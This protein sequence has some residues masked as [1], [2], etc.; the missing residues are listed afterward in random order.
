MADE[1][2]VAAGDVTEQVNAEVS[3]DAGESGAADPQ[4]NAN[5]GEQAEHKRLGGWQRKIQKLEREVQTLR[6]KAA[7]VVEQ[8]A[9]APK[10]K[11]EPKDFQIEGTETYD[12]AKYAEAVADWK[13]ESRLAEADKKRTEAQKVE[14][15]KSEQQKQLEAWDSK[16]GAAA[17]AK[18]KDFSE[19]IQSAD[20]PVSPLMHEAIMASDNGGDLA[21]YFASNEEQ[22]LAISRMSPY[23]QAKEIAKI[24]AQFA[25]QGSAEEDEH[26]DAP[27]PPVKK[28]PAPPTPVSKPSS[29]AHQFDPVK[30]ADMPYKDWIRK[31]EAQLKRK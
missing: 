30:D 9:E 27:V 14:Q 1:Q 29:A 8:V 28:A 23:Q 24:E 3:T 18:Y 10:P 15:Q 7:P 11:P 4:A 31:R 19:V 21:Y 22:A 26:E 6:Q 17:K 12:V 25:P 5:D 2:V 16:Q 13:V 20:F